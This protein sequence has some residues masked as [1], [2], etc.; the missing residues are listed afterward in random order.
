M[1]LE[2]TRLL[3]AAS[4]DRINSPVLAGLLEDEG[5][6]D[7]TILASLRTCLPT[8]AE[9]EPLVETARKSLHST[10]VADKIAAIQLEMKNS[11]SDRYWGKVK[12]G[13][14]LQV[15]YVSCEI[16]ALYGT[17]PAGHVWVRKAK[18]SNRYVTC[19]RDKVGPPLSLLGLWNLAV[20]AE[21][22]TSR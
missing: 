16:H 10:L 21:L 20:C 3:V 4:Q 2:S 1:I 11:I 15:G 6:T 14:L 5:C 19:R 7:S 22:A 17:P 18:A 8:K 13:Y 12:I 9:L